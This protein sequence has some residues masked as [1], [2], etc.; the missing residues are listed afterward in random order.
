MAKS[1]TDAQP[2]NDEFSRIFSEYRARIDEITRRTE[3]R[4]KTFSEEAEGLAAA[5][6]VI[7]A[8]TENQP[9]ALAEARP[10]EREE[11]EPAP[12]E[13]QPPALAEARPQEREEEEPAP[14]ENQPPALAEARPQEREEEEPAPSPQHTPPPPRSYPIPDVSLSESAMT[15]REARQKAKKIVEEAEQRVKKEAKKKTQSQV[16]KLLEAARKEAEEIVAS[17]RQAAENEKEEIIAIARQEAER[18]ITDITEKCRQE[19]QASSS[20]A[21]TEAS[22]K[23]QKIMGEVV[24]SGLKINRLMTE[25]LDRTGKTVTEFEER[26]REESADLNRVVEE[27]RARLDEVTAAARE[28]AATPAAAPAPDEP[29][30]ETSN[31]TLTVHFLG[32]K[33]NG[34]NGTPA[35]FSGQVEMK[36]SSAIDY[37]YLKSLKKYLVSNP[38]VKYLQEYASE[39]EMSVLFDIRQPL[40][41]LDVLRRMPLVADIISGVT[42][43]DFDIIFQENR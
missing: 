41:L 6:A 5:I 18:A 10:Q 29:E 8:P 14:P 36:S 4:L 28:A 15:I 33:S 23:A 32:E 20:R 11:E 24:E 27:T 16:D 37:Q 39:K 22:G 34:K 38:D 3:K 43:E 1:D 30:E 12:P 17:T 42:D 25:I 40:P 21:M 7:P 19:S 31:P 9:P 2:K 13:N 26:L 35:L